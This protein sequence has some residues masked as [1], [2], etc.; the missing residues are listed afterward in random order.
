MGG[1]GTGKDKAV[2]L[3]DICTISTLDEPL[4]GSQQGDCGLLKRHWVKERKPG[5]NV[6]NIKMD[7]WAQSSR[8]I[9]FKILKQGI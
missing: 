6:V 2:S 9:L 7:L 5:V 8:S 1:N 4:A 3:C